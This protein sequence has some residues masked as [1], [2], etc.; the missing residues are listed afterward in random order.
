MLIKIGKFC[1]AKLQ[2]LDKDSCISKFQY[3]SERVNNFTHSLK[4]FP[5]FEK[6]GKHSKLSLHNTAQH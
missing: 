4:Y 5:F 2:Q 3:L 1:S 6:K